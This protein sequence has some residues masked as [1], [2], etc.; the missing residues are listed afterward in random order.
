M[1][2][3]FR[4]KRDSST[5]S[6]ILQ[7]DRYASSDARDHEESLMTGEEFLAYFVVVVLLQMHYEK[8]MDIL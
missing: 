3:R 6:T 5:R 4:H 7:Q 1:F 8:T 2:A